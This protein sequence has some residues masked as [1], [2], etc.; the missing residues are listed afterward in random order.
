MQT[1]DLCRP[2]GQAQANSLDFRGP[3]LRMTIQRGAIVGV[4][5]SRDPVLHFAATAWRRLRYETILGG[6]G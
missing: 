4:A 3:R 2:R 5:F 1:N 6:M